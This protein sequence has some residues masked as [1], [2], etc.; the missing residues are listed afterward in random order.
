MFE[1]GE[2]N[3]KTLDELMNATL[4]TVAVKEEVASS[5][6]EIEVGDMRKTPE[7]L[8]I[9]GLNGEHYEFLTNYVSLDVVESDGDDVY[10]FCYSNGT[11]V[12]IGSIAA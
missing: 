2:K 8:I 10:K 11:K 9:E 6:V 5:F 4:I 7:K 12:E 3:M 1:R